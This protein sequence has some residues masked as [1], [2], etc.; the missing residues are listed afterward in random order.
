MSTKNLETLTTAP[1][2]H[3]TKLAIWLADAIFS[4]HRKTDGTCNVSDSALNQIARY[5]P[6]NVEPLF[7]K[8]LNR[9][10]NA[11]EIAAAQRKADQER[12][13]S[14]LI[15]TAILKRRKLRALCRSKIVNLFDTITQILEKHREDDFTLANDPRKLAQYITMIE[16]RHF[17]NL[18]PNQGR[19]EG[20]AY[21]DLLPLYTCSGELEAGSL[22]YHQA[23]QERPYWHVGRDGGGQPEIRF[24]VNPLLTVRACKLVCRIG[25]QER[26]GGHIHINCQKNTEIGTRVYAAFR[27]H[28]VWFRYL[29]NAS[30]R[31]G[32]W[33]SV[34]N[35][36]A[37]F[38][39]ARRIKGAAISCN[40]W[41]RTGTV[42]IR[43]WGTTSKPA[44]WAFRTRLMQSMA[45]MSETVE[46]LNP[47]PIHREVCIE[48]FMS[49]AC[50][51]VV[52]DPQTLREL[53]NAFRK[54]TRGTR[55]RIGAQMAGQLVAGFDASELV[56]RGY[57]RRA[58]I[59]ENTNAEITVAT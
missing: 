46:H 5:L 55:D 42:E 2:P 37:H 47:P 30:R 24:R 50:W 9:K 21:H 25:S 33:S 1:I 45:Q 26:N 56:L 39:E 3:P 38:T 22:H 20:K 28:L 11:A 41:Q 13:L 54:K 29:A 23:R 43:I 58:T 16:K 44:E 32:R 4:E 48:A 35:T 7:W 27:T 6:A 49:Y 12:A 10:R 57:R 53:L 14:K 17:G 40:T 15:G 52:N 19:Y 51:A 18:P 8:S 34:A 36:P 59:T 31:N